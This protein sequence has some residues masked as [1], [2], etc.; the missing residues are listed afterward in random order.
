MKL[1]HPPINLAFKTLLKFSQF[2]HRFLSFPLE[3][4]L[5]PLWPHPCFSRPSALSIRLDQILG[6]Q[7]GKHTEH[8]SLWNRH[9]DG[10]WRELGTSKSRKW[11]WG[12]ATTGML[13]R[14]AVNV[15][16]S[17]GWHL[18]KDLLDKGCWI[19]V[20]ARL[21]KAPCISALFLQDSE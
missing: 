20:E 18:S 19:Y 21:P 12:A 9:L 1:E 13:F 11:G 4:W 8:L 5:L 7:Q 15:C 10:R 2:W 14:S 16:P 17:D 6:L 3:T